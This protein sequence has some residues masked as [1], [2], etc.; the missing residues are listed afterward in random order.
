MISTRDYD[1]IYSAYNIPSSK[2]INDDSPL[3]YP[4][5]GEL[6]TN[7]DSIDDLF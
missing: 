1:E 4:D 2:F 3:L 5:L 6:D 7:I